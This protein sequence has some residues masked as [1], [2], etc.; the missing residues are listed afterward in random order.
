[1][2]TMI[3]TVPKQLLMLTSTTQ[4]PM[5]PLEIFFTFGFISVFAVAILATLFQYL[6]RLI[7]LLSIFAANNR[8]SSEKYL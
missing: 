5:S 1:M 4:S 2:K 8:H 6:P 3:N 7:F